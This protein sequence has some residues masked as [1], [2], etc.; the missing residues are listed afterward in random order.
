M[1]ARESQ[2]IFVPGSAATQLFGRGFGDFGFPDF[3]RLQVRQATQVGE[4]RIGDR[5]AVQVKAAKSWKAEK[6]RQSAIG[7]VRLYKPQ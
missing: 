1:G 2:K 6:T 3:K 5:I 7:D 4:P